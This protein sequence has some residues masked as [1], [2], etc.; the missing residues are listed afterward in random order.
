MF[1]P[2]FQRQALYSTASPVHSHLCVFAFCLLLLVH[3]FWRVLYVCVLRRA[4]LLGAL[5]V[6]RR[7]Q[8]VKHTLTGC[9]SKVDVNARA[10]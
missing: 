1:A 6:R 7:C 10:D 4:A 3:A 2:T 5:G 8:P 9:V